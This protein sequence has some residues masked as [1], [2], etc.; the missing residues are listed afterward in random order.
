MLHQYPRYLLHHLR[1][2]L[3]MLNTAGEHLHI[4]GHVPLIINR[5]SSFAS[6]QEQVLNTSTTPKQQVQDT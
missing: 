5:S 3:E 2:V 4:L 6:Y 1:H